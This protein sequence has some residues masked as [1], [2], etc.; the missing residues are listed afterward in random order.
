MSV[1]EAMYWLFHPYQPLLQADARF[2]DGPKQEQPCAPG[3]FK[4]VVRSIL[5][6]EVGSHIR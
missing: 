2:G 1:V 6:P 4:C 5:N 3:V